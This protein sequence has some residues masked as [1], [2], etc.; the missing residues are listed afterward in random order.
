MKKFKKL[1]ALTLVSV[2]ALSLTACGQ[3]QNG[4]DSETT[5]QSG[6]ADATENNDDS[7]KTIVCGTN[8]E[9]PPFEYINDN[10][11]VDG[12]DMAVV[13]EIAARKGYQVE[14]TNMEFKSLIGALSTGS[15]D[16]V[17]A[18]MTVTD[19]R[20]QSVDFSDFYYTANQSIIVK[21]DSDI[22]SYEDLDGKV[23][24][25]QEGT[26][27]DFIATDDI[28]SKEVKRFKK[29]V[30]AVM[31]LKNGSVD[32]VIIDS[33]PANEFV[34]VDPEAIKAIP[35]TGNEEQYALAVKKG[36]Q[37]LLNVLNEGLAEIKADGT[38]DDLVKQ[39]INN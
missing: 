2:F 37:E 4:E 35:T 39:Y 34:K 16:V 3:S 7:L 28:N 33:N 22:T 11:D 14:F 10:G 9:F 6:I 38:F 12:F 26:T 18:G 31:D 8:A 32:A 23:I 27:G 25:V 20:K 30:D 15:L 19:E 17:A 13:K 36:N 5:T 1:I 24:A 21:S 29:G